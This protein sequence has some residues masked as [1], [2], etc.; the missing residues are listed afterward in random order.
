MNLP[1]TTWTLV[2]LAISLAAVAWIVTTFPMDRT[3][4]ALASASFAGVA[5][6]LLFK[7][8]GALA[9]TG[10]WHAVQAHGRGSFAAAA[11]TYLASLHAGL[12]GPGFLA[13]DAYRALG[14]GLRRADAG[15]GAVLAER[16]VSFTALA[17]GAALGAWLSPAA[18]PL[19]LPM[20]LLAALGIAGVV[21]GALAGGWLALRVPGHGFAARAARQALA[22]MDALREP[23]V[24]R[25]AVVAAVALPVFT[26]AA[27]W[28]AFR[29]VGASP[30]LWFTLAAANA[31]ALLVL[32]PVSVQGLGLREGAYVGLFAG[33]AHLPAETALAASLLS[34]FG[35]LAL[36]ALAGVAHWWPAR[37]AR[38]TAPTFSSFRDVGPLLLLAPLLAPVLAAERGT[39]GG[40]LQRL[41]EV[42][43]ALLAGLSEEM[44]YLPPGSAPLVMIFGGLFVVSMALLLSMLQPALAGLAGQGQAQAAG[45][46]AGRQGTGEGFDYMDPDPEP[47]SRAVAPATASTVVES[48]GPPEEVASLGPPMPPTAAPPPAAVVH[49][50]ELGPAGPGHAPPSAAV[51]GTTPR[52]TAGRTFDE[53]LAVG[54]ALAARDVD[55]ILDGAERMGLGEAHLVS[56]EPHRYVV[57]LASC[58]TCR[59][60]PGRGQGPGGCEFERGFLQGAASGLAPATV[61]SEAF[62]ARA[63]DGA[64]EFDLRLGR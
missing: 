48:S 26:A 5:A 55:A 40:S 20:T 16:A 14:A 6:V 42:L 32:L 59:L 50:S 9:S 60:R 44:A 53:G 7:F 46:G 61:V 35:S 18:A 39:L 3:A 34:L 49:R 63:A 25:R 2:R 28:A 43:R 24:A 13:S 31:A 19:R 10:I 36:G 38:N 4:A 41:F 54:R 15:L 33:L 17:V 12:L 29:A 23:T 52:P 22:G 8:L 62:C 51:L 27:T 45:A 57:R 21:A 11:R 64:C 37:E 58:G 56:V 1:P 30:G 47:P